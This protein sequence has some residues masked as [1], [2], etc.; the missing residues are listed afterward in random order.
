MTVTDREVV[1]GERSIRRNIEDPE[2][3]CARIPF[4]CPAVT[5]DGDG[6][7]RDQG[8][9]VAWVFGR[10]EDVRAGNGEIDGE[11]REIAAHPQAILVH[12][13][14][15]SRN[16]GLLERAEAVSIYLQ[17]CIRRID[18]DDGRVRL[19]CRSC[20]RDDRGDDPCRRDEGG[21][22][23]FRNAN[24]ASENTAHETPLS[25]PDV[26]RMV[27]AVT[28]RTPSPKATRRNYSIS[29]SEISRE[30]SGPG[31]APAQSGV[32]LQ[33]FALSRGVR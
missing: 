18:G 8:Q 1:Q 4:Q 14:A 19:R 9:T 32:Q 24:D 29:G 6:L 26:W 12:A 31:R 17:V 23:P 27:G 13:P 22:G 3:P 20:Y 15:L 30:S 25:M 7:G 5:L 33:P 28:G 10:V 21:D 16:D 2:L 11:L